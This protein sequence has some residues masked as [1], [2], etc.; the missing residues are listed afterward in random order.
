M[1]SGSFAACS[2]HQIPGPLFA[3]YSRILPELSPDQQYL[4]EN[5]ESVLSIVKA[6]LAYTIYPDIPLFRDPDL[7]YCTIADLPSLPFGIFYRHDNNH[8]VLKTFV[9]LCKDTF[10]SPTDFSGTVI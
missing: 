4:T 5:L 3:L 1:L 10:S 7:C 2:P 8:E 6:G 9:R